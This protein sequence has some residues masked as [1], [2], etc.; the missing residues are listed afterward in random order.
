MIHALLRPLDK[1]RAR[2]LRHLGSVA[3]PFIVQRELRVGAA[4]AL[5]VMLALLG[6]LVLPL[7]MLALGPLI[8]GV[9]HI[10]S[11]V[12]YLVVRPGHHRRLALAFAAGLP[13]LAAA[14]GGG[15]KAGLCAAIGALCVAR[16][17][18]WR[19][20]LGVTVLTLAVAGAATLGWAA[21]VL[22]AHAHNF[23]A[24]ALWWAWRPRGDR[25][26]VWPLALF[27]VATGVILG[28]A[29]DPWLASA[30]DAGWALDGQSGRYFAIQLA[31]GLPQ[32]WGLRMV[33][34]FAFAQT[35]HYGIWLRLI[36]EDDRPHRTP[37]SFLASWRALEADFG[38]WALWGTLAACAGLM[39]WAMLDL[40]G[41][42]VGYL[43]LANFHGHLE[44]AAAALLFAEGR[45]GASTH[46]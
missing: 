41:A 1:W 3:R 45:P 16:G 36:P 13:L 9:P 12:R 7:W 11:D 19:R 10:L 39:S 8:W 33:M 17:A 34:L 46:S 25:W 15:V 23:I 21:E 6:A 35:V 14:L 2:L 30:F 44:L 40:L 20:A 31:P 4:G 37:R 24:V 22:F 32:T 5:V 18:L 38:R 43:R 42:R 26:S 28:G 29:A 27:V